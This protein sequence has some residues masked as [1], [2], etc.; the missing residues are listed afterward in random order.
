MVELLCYELGT[1]IIYEIST[2]QLIYQNNETN[3]FK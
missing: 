3:L 1:Y 2:E